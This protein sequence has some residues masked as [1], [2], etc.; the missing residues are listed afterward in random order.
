VLEALAPA[1]VIADAANNPNTI[2]TTVAFYCCSMNIAMPA[3]LHF[4]EPWACINNLACC[5]RHKPC[6]SQ[7]LQVAAMDATHLT[8]A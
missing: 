3:K 2:S 4:Q 5:L 7:A 1:G 8:P 6:D